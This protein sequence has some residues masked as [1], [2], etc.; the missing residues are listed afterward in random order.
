MSE[1]KP[2]TYSLSH[3]KYYQEHKA[4]ILQRSRETGAYERKYKSAYER[5]KEVIKQKAL[6]RYY[7][8]KTQV[9]PSPPAETSGIT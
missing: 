6:A 2:S 7:A 9:T 4:E 8:K 5:N 3:K 1:V